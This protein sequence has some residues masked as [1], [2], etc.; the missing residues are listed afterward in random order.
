MSDIEK[1]I[2]KQ[3]GILAA[4]RW[5]HF[6]HLLLKI[7]QVRVFQDNVEALS[8]LKAPVEADDVGR[9]PPG[10]LKP[11]KSTALGIKVYFGFNSSIGLDYIDTFVPLIRVL[12][13]L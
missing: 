5:R 4:R 10:F 3:N 6:F 2:P 12:S 9:R 8:S 11:P 1:I 7:A 13:V